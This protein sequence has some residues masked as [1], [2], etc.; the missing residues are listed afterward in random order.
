MARLI[1][2]CDAQWTRNEQ[3]TP[4]P[5]PFSSLRRRITGPT[6]FARPTCLPSHALNLDDQRCVKVD[7]EVKPD[8]GTPHRRPARPSRGR[9]RSPRVA[10]H[11][12]RRPAGDQAAEV[13]HV[14]AVAHPEDEAHVVVDEQASRPPW[15]RSPS[16]ASEGGD[17]GH[18]EAGAGLVEEQDLRPQRERAGHADQLLMTERELGRLAAGG[19][20]E[21]DEGDRVA[22]RRPMPARSAAPRRAASSRRRGGSSSLTRTLSSTERSSNSSTDCQVRTRPLRART[23]AGVSPSGSPSSRTCPEHGV[24]P[25]TA[26]MKLVLPAPFGPI[27][28]TISPARPSG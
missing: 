19:V 26:S 4:T 1:Q 18:V 23:L 14:H 11:A 17:L 20:F 21:A 10:A 3:R 16:A 28:P 7:G 6:G 15:R 2:K 24:N 13:D 8:P 27:S 12:V 9:R 5:M 25:V 22:D